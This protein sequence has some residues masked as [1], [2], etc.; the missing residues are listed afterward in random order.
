LREVIGEVLRDER[1]TQERTLAEVAADAF[2]SLA[3]LS[4]VERGRKEPSSEILGS[5]SSALGIPLADVLERAAGALRARA[6]R[7]GRVQ[8]L[9]A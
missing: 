7:D 6:Q 1:L 8:L 5:I 4:E 3:Y 2:V 9:A